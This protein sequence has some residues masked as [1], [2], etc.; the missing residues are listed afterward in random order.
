MKKLLC[1]VLVL[2]TA[3]SVLSGCGGNSRSNDEKSEISISVFDRGL[4][5]SEEGDYSNNRW[6]KW[7][8]E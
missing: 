1:L 3:L 8:E 2:V 5:S 4:I 6:T 7:M